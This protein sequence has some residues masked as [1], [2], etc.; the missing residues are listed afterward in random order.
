[1]ERTDEN[2]SGLT[3]WRLVHDLIHACLATSYGAPNAPELVEAALAQV[4]EA[5]ALRDKYKPQVL[6]VIEL[7]MDDD[8]DVEDEGF[9]PLIS[10]SE[11]SGVW[12]SVSKWVPMDE[13]DE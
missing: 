5:H 2:Y 9:Y 3:N 6:Q 13:G 12:I 8:S 4:D 1:M 7:C 11:D 10:E